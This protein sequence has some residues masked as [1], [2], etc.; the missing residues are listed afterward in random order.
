MAEWD[1]V[2]VKAVLERNLDRRVP[3]TIWP[4][5][6]PQEHAVIVINGTP[7]AIVA[8][9]ERVLLG[10][11][12]QYASAEQPPTIFAYSDLTGIDAHLPWIGHRF[13]TLT[14]PGPGEDPGQV[15]FDQ[16]PFSAGI[17]FRDRAATEQAVRELNALI[18]DQNG[19]EDPPNPAHTGFFQGMWRLGRNFGGGRRA[20]WRRFRS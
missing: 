3:P 14:G 12:G 15:K 9:N 8:T 16:P 11:P 13:V 2:D 1:R 20:A 5:I 17:A 4:A 19:W 6:R 10:R 7:G 18:D